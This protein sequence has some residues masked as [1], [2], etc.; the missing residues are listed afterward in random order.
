[1]SRGDLLT[2]FRALGDR[3]PAE[4]RLVCIMSALNKF[5]RASGVGPADVHWFTVQCGLELSSLVMAPG[6]V[7]ALLEV[8]VSTVKAGDITAAALSLASLLVKVPVEIVSAEEYVRVV[9]WVLSRPFP[10]A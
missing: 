10:L 8:T 4:A 9:P 3:L 6:G 2:A 1:M 7:L 5:Q